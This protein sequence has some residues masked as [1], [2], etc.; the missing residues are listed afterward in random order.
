[1]HRHVGLLYVTT[2]SSLCA[3]IVSFYI[4]RAMHLV[5][6]CVCVCVRVRVRVC[7]CVE[8]VRYS[9]H[10]SLDN[11]CSNTVFENLQTCSYIATLPTLGT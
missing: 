5:Y 2:M 6:V 7:A 8:G 4:R 10:R 11:L 9:N 3:Y 1:M